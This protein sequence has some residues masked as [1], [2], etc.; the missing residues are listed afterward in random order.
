MIFTAIILAGGKSSRMGQ[1]KG[2]ALYRGKRMI[3]HVVESCKKLTPKILISTN[4]QEYS[5]LGYPLVED[6]FKEMGPIG[7]LQAGLV[8]SETFDNIFCSCDMPGIQPEVLIRF[9]DK[10]NND[11]QAVVAANSKGNF[12]PVL[13]YYNKSVLPVIEKQI[14]KGDFK[15]QHLLKELNVQSMVFPDEVL[16]N[17]NY[18][19]DLR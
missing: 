4:N 16:K 18:P 5:F 13:G 1:D 12:F 8:A 19:E 15:M 6:N 14:A 9:L 11:S 3:E 10:K 2:L 7:G 17:I